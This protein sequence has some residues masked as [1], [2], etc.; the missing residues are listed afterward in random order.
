MVETIAPVVHGGRNRSYYLSVATHTIGSTGSAALFGL[1]L[2]ALGILLGA[3]YRNEVALGAIAAVAGLYALRE[4]G[5]LRIPLPDLDRQ[6]PDWWRTFFAPP[7]ASFL[8]GTGLGVGFLTYLSF[9]TLVP[10][11]TGAVVLGEPVLGAAVMAPFG[12]ARGL[13]VLIAARRAMS[14][15]ET[16]D[17]LGAP[18]LRRAA[19]LSNGVVLSAIVV[20]A[21]V[22]LVS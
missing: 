20:V 11:A 6:V 14:P 7:V 3:P 13:S 10:V 16:V 12:L 18:K 15:E 5:G 19:E 1:G 17:R 2:G 4:L 22:S 8:Y 9:G 21:I